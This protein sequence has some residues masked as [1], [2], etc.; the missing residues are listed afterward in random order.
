M[1]HLVLV[2]EVATLGPEDGLQEEEEVPDEER[3]LLV[4]GRERSSST[5]QREDSK[6]TK[7]FSLMPDATL[8][9]Q[10]K[11]SIINMNNK[12]TSTKIIL[13]SASLTGNLA[14]NGN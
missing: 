5:S 4:E 12:S 3:P 13:T 10:V 11:I 1:S 6:L 2:T 8:S 7:H 14:E 9:N